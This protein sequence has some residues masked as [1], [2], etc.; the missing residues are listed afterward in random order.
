MTTVDIEGNLKSRGFTCG[1]A[2]AAS[3]GST[4]LQTVECNSTDGQHLF[5]VVFASESGTRVRFLSASITPVSAAAR[6]RIDEAA[7]LFLGFMATLPYSGAKPTE[8][9][10]WVKENVVR[11]GTSMTI[12]TAWFEID[13]TPSDINSRRLNIVAV[14]ART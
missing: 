13:P 8:A 5:S 12:G 7:G 9:Q 11:P 3:A 10:A 2:K 1:A 14:G 6:S 4:A